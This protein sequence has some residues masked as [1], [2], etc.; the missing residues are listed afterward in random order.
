MS[1]RAAIVVS[2]FAAVAV[3]GCGRTQYGVGCEKAV[4]L[5]SP[6]LEMKLPIDESQTRVCDATADGLKLRSHVWSRAEEAA[7]AF[8]AALVAVGYTKDRCSGATCYYQNDGERVSV[9]PIEFR[10]KRNKRLVTVILR[11]RKA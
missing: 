7:P 5:G 1:L 9:Q 8:E 2:S 11:R 4:E 3:V 6:W 10:V